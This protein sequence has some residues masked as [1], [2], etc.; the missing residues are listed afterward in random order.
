MKDSMLFPSRHRS[1]Q[2]GRARIEVL[3]VFGVGKTTLVENLSKR[4]SIVPL[5]EQYKANAYWGNRSVLDAFGYLG[6]DLSFLLHHT[7][8]VQS[9]T[10]I[11]ESKREIFCDWSFLTDRVWARARLKDDEYRAYSHTHQLME[12]L[13]GKPAAYVHIDLAPEI[14]LQR[15]QRRGRPEELDV[16]LAMLKSA[17]DLIGKELS[18]VKDIPVHRV[19]SDDEVDSILDSSIF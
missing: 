13:C 16:D 10:T 7:F 9:A 8:L 4:R 14:I 5:Y 2:R 18:D 1:G 15:I 12:E 3:G 19:S 6:Y 11:N 17:S